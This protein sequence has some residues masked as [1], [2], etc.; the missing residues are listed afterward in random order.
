MQNSPSRGIVFRLLGK[1]L[2]RDYDILARFVRSLRDR[3]TGWPPRSSRTAHPDRKTP[4]NLRAEAVVEERQARALA[5]RKSAEAQGVV[6]FPDDTR[7]ITRRLD[8]KD[9][10]ERRA[11]ANQKAIDDRRRANSKRRRAKV[12]VP[13]VLEVID[14][15][16][17]ISMQELERAGVVRRR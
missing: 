14:E 15:A 4:A 8:I 6:W 16:S 3:F 12:S 1:E 2:E 5:R 10:K 17:S 13:E 7:G 11:A 9:R